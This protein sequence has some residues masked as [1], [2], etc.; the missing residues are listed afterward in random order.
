M[1]FSHS[2]QMKNFGKQLS[3]L[4][5]N[6][7][8]KTA[9]TDNIIQD[10]FENDSTYANE[11]KCEVKLFYEAVLAN[12]VSEFEVKKVL[13]VEALMNRQQRWYVNEYKI[14]KKIDDFFLTMEGMGQYLMY[15][16]LIHPKG[17]KYFC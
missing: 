3:I 10:Y 15:R 6:Q 17:G 16:W 5:H 9:F 14:F 13:A 2:Q 12:T 8:Y 4:E 1:S 7:I 11:F